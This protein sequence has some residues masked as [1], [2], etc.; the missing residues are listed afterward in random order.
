MKLFD[1][2][3]FMELQGHLLGMELSLD[4]N[5]DQIRKE[6][7]VYDEFSEGTLKDI[8]TSFGNVDELL[9]LINMEL[10][11]HVYDSE[12]NY[13]DRNMEI[14][15][16]IEKEL[17]NFQKY[18]ECKNISTFENMVNF[19]HEVV[20]KCTELGNKVFPDFN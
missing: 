2:E 12:D 3:S 15:E 6:Y 4:E 7:N 8:L 18:I 1:F 5:I 9:E 20:H 14:L 13:D 17:N 11:S 10:V 16:S 19:I